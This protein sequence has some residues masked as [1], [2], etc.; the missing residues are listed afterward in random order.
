LTG[1]SA[2]PKVS[3]EEEEEPMI[4]HVKFAG[5]P[6][7][8]QDRSLAFYTQKLGFK[9]ATDQPMGPGQRWIE[10]KIPRAE[11][12][13][14]LFTPPGHEDRVGT[15]WNGS[16]ACDDVEETYEKLKAAGVEFVKPPEKQAWGTYVVAKDPDGN[17]LVFSS[18]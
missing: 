8:D 11:T 9:V 15:Q 2:D 3:P 16:F 18:R 4:T 10:L 6:V 13:V 12:G 5:I 1:G 7:S 17:Q 14:V